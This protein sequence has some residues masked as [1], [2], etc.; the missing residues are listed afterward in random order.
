MNILVFTS[1]MPDS[2]FSSYQDEA[3]IKPNP[4]N[5]NFY[6]KLIKALAI[7]N[8]VSVIS[9]R[10]LV[11][12]MFRHKKALY[13]DIVMDGN[14]KYYLTNVRSDKAFKLIEEQKTI[15]KTANSAI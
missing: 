8:N 15:V 3:L 1:S 14:V 2:M 13:S 10:P 7:N 12:G 5:Q 11:K 9:H 6:S 4:S